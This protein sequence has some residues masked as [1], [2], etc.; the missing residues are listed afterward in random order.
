MRNQSARLIV[1][2]SL[3]AGLATAF[4]FG[5]PTAATQPPLFVR[6]YVAAS[7]FPEVAVGQ[8]KLE[9][10]HLPGVQVTLVEAG[11]SAP[12]T[13]DLTDLSGRFTLKLRVPGLYRV[14]VEAKGFVPTCLDRRLELADRSLY[15][16]D[17]RLQPERSQQTAQVY[18]RVSLRDGS[19]P[20]ALQPL[21]GT[22]AYATVELDD[23]SG[24]VTQALVN[25]HGEYVVPLAPVAALFALRAT[26]DGGKVEQ[27]VDPRTG[28]VPNFAYRFD[29]QIDDAPPKIV[30]IAI[31]DAS[32]LPAETARPGETVTLRATAEDADG[33]PLTWRWLVTDGNGSLDATDTPEVKWK[34]PGL[35]G[36]YTLTLLV[37]DGRGG[38]AERRL[39]FR[40]STGGVRFSGEVTDTAGAAVPR[41]F[42]EVNGRTVRA[43]FAGYFQIEVP[44][45]AKYVLNA[46]APGFGPASEVYA[47]G[48]TAGRWPLRRAEVFTVDPT[49]PV[50]VRQERRPKNECPGPRSRSLPWDEGYLAPGIVQWQDGRGNALSVTETAVGDRLAATEVAGL[51]ARVDRSFLS[52]ARELLGVPVDDRVV[53][54]IPCGPG[55]GVEL[56]PDSLV[57]RAGNAPTGA[58]EVALS[59]VDLQSP[60][61]MLGD[62]GAVDA[63]GKEFVM[64]SFG[65]GTIEITSG[66]TPLNIRSGATATVTLPVD[67]TQLATGSPPPTIPLLFYDDRRGLWVEEGQ[68]T[69]AGS[70]YEAQVRH[71]SSLNA[72]FLNVPDPACVAIRSGPGLPASYVVEVHLPAKSPATAPQ[73]RSFTIDTSTG[74][75]H[76]IYRLPPNTN[77]ALVPIVAGTRPDG[78]SGDVPAGVFVVN[79]GA[80]QIAAVQ[81]PPGPPYY[82]TDASGNPL[83][84][85][86][87]RVDLANL[88]IPA[89]PDPPYEF[90][91][92]LDVQS[93]NLTELDSSDPVLAQSIRDASVAYY[94]LVDPRGLRQDLLD[95]K[96]R[97]RFGQPLDL[98]NGELEA[99]A[100]YANSGDLGF[101][102]NMNCR[103]N[104]ASDGAFDIACYV[105]NYGDHLTPDATDAADAASQNATQ[106]IAT[107]AMEYTRVENPPGDPIE[108]PDDSRTVK[109][110]V[111]AKAQPSP[112]HPGQPNGRVISADLDGAGQRPVPQ[113]CVVCHGGAYASEPADPAD[114]GGLQKPAFA[115]RSDVFMGSRFIPFDLHFFTDPP[116]PTTIAAQETAF[117]SLNLDF[118]ELVPDGAPASD[119]VLELINELYPLVGGVPAATQNDA[120]VVPNWDKASPASAD[121]QF[122]RDVFARACR[123]CHINAPFGT[124]VLNNKT[125][126]RSLIA[127]VQSRVCNQHVMP[128]A[129]RTHDLFWTSLGPNMAARLQLYG[130]AIPGWDPN[131]PEAQCGLSFTPGGNTPLSTFTQ[132][133]QP[134]FTNRCTIC[135]GA[136]A[137]F[138]AQ[139]ALSAGNAYTNINGVTSFE[140]PP[141]PR[142]QPGTSS[143]SYLSRKVEGT[144]AA[145][146]GAFNLPPGATPPAGDPMPQGG[147]TFNSVDTDGDGTNDLDEVLFWI[148][149]LGAPG[150]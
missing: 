38:Y 99:S 102:R 145:L 125:D 31:S 75:E 150:P 87:T 118:V 70:V 53:E 58:V 32:G 72:D 44:R 73:V 11:G 114:P 149:T 54:D 21:L 22:N 23:G 16:G 124:I 36:R 98:A 84:P 141:T 117:R 146:G 131:T 14:C 66:G 57:N 88:T 49:Q 95:F 56:P 103:R 6:G 39:G 139:L 55:I 2:C 63:S 143:N 34:L 148:D 127:T 41:A 42:V 92:G 129:R 115:L 47:Q 93:T 94:G 40:V 91:Q 45:G 130:Q 132:E 121:H 90:L 8:G 28:L 142:I 33:D 101:G 13:S 86:L 137:Q 12:V 37:S 7:L 96:S 120:A 147:P 59:T 97:N 135:H 108:F 144:H 126:F 107:V 112:T 4:P 128:H 64:E 76:V 138:N 69:L 27:Q 51:L 9:T 113:L 60:G 29:L 46:R 81:P 43:D 104:R 133:I 116:A 3:G 30:N 100:V 140:H 136:A 35:N 83:G 78:S 26:I 79:T 52:L 48:V 106:E 15:V 10:V 134:I 65:A 24:G 110:Y 80:P 17:I 19:R 50:G 111:Y 74:S 61:Q 62:M 1:C 122:Y 20:R 25:N 105:T 18:G 5:A 119:P 68:W 77:I 82:N 71:L 109:F 89:A 67:P 85:C 123:S